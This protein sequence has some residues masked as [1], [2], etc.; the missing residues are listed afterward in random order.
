[1][2]H[3]NDAQ[4]LQQRRRFNRS[5]PI[6]A[7]VLLVLI[8]GMGVGM[9]F[10]Y[11]LLANPF[12]VIAQLQS[13]HLDESTLTTAAMLLPILFWMLTISLLLFVLLGWQLMNNEKR[14]LGILESKAVES[15]AM[16]SKETKTGK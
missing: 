6:A 9:A 15:K 7:T 12:Y 14:L 4:F 3:Q 8:V 13:G 5:W 1:M 10:T 11:P 16:E 2:Q